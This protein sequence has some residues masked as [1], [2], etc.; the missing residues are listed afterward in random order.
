M[1]GGSGFP[2]F[3]PFTVEGSGM[4]ARAVTLLAIA[5]IMVAL[6]ARACSCLGYD[7]AFEQGEAADIV[8]VGRVIHSG[9]EADR[10]PLWRRVLDWRS[11]EAPAHRRHVTTFQVDEALR[12]APAGDIAIGHLPGVH[13]ASC[14][15][16]FS[17]RERRVV[18]AWQT[19]EGGYSTSACHLPQFSEADFLSAFTR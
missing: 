11:R 19:P 1:T 13:A 7:S 8:F 15:V 2:N 12:G 17:G 4:Y 18:L 14:G 10:R 9:P 16:D 6:P 3:A 5:A